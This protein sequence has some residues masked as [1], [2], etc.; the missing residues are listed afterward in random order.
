M[1]LLHACYVVRSNVYTRLSNLAQVKE[2]QVLSS[3]WAV[4][5]QHG[6]VLLHLNVRNCGA[7]W[8]LFAIS[9]VLQV[10]R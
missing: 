2:W 1:L 4:V 5:F 7:C 6:V 8:Y 10:R 9:I 3:D